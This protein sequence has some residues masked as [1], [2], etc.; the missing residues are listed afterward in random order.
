MRVICGFKV[1]LW[2]RLGFKFEV[3]DW[4]EGGQIWYAEKEFNDLIFSLR[5]NTNSGHVLAK[6]E[7]LDRQKL[8]NHVVSEQDAIIWFSSKSPRFSEACEI[9]TKKAH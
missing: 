7:T 1:D 4:F 2:E 5:I 6:I 3:S 8:G 9:Q